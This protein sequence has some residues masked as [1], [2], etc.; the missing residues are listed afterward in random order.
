MDAARPDRGSEFGAKFDEKEIMDVFKSAKHF[1]HTQND[2][3]G[4]ARCL[5]W[6][7]GESSSEL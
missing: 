4:A 3:S 6:D 5:D 1:K 7:P 2:Q